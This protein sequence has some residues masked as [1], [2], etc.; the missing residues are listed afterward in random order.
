MKQKTCAYGLWKSELSPKM[1]A[2][3]IRFEDVAWSGESLLWRE[4]RSGWGAILIQRPG[5]APTELNTQVS[6][7]GCVGYGG[8]SFAVH[9][10]QLYFC[11][12]DGRL[13]SMS[14]VKGFEKPITPKFGAIGSPTPS[15]N[16]KWIAY[17][18]SDEGCDR[19]AL[20]DSEGK[21]W[22]II[23]VSGA[24]FYMQPAWSPDGNRLA[25]IAWDHPNMP[26][27]GARLESAEILYMDDG[28]PTLGPV[29][30]LAGGKSIS[31]QQPAFSP[32]GQF[33]AYLSDESGYLHLY[34][35]DLQTAERRQL[36]RGAYDY[37]GPAWVQ[38][39][40]S[41]LWS[42]DETIIAFPQ[43]K[44]RMEMQRIA[45]DGQIFSVDMPPHYSIFL[46]PAIS[47]QGALA[48][49][50]SSN[51]VPTRVVSF[52][53]DKEYIHAFSMV[54]R[55]PS[56]EYSVMESLTWADP[57]SG[58]PV[59]GNYYPPQNEAFCSQ[60]LPPTILCIHGGPT[61]DSDARFNVRAQFFTQRGFAVM[62][63]N[64]RGSS[65]Y[66]REYMQCLKGNWG[67]YDVEDA[68]SAAR[69]LVDT[70]RA[71]ADGIA[72]MGGSAGGYT[73][74]QAITDCPGVF[75]AA[76]CLYGVSNL[77]T[78]DQATHKFESEYCSGL[79]GSLPEAAD[80]WRARSPIFKVDQ[81]QDSVLVFHGAEDKAVPIEQAEV[82]VNSLRE[83]GKDC[84]YHVYP[85]EGHGWRRS[86]NIEHFYKKTLEFLVNRLV[87]G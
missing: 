64:Y 80:V 24:D 71:S 60:G 69:F 59:F 34:L 39:I 44:G 73:V 32:S 57:A 9:E 35:Q 54:E 15:P 66:G 85:N 16:G 5:Q 50:A 25:W 27:D 77:F 81:I 67:R 47:K 19:I 11:G 33:V 21:N 52:R 70:G 37:A 87:L 72:I 68:V 12:R 7:Q 84:E 63:L 53:E 22:P 38:G 74:L 41:F 4:E 62:E 42:S 26:W 23:L 30:T 58:E 83:S 31:V 48:V 13:Y 8:G 45:I 86:E 78:L 56:R 20:I 10:D 14:I 1:M 40:R 76:V 46:Q 43:Q 3:N 51:Q 17:I 82:I 65:G 61:S 55:L 75:R 36:T 79:L 49:I 28:S 2:K 6:A 29:S 18:H